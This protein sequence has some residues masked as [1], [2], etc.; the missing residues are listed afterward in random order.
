MAEVDEI[1]ALE[2]V[3]DGFCVG[4]VSSLTGDCDLVITATGVPSVVDEE[5]LSNVRD[6]TLLANAGHFDREF[7]LPALDEMT[8]GTEELATHRAEHTP[9]RPPSRRHRARPHGEPRRTATQRQLHRVDG[10][11]VRVASTL[12]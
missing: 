1:K 6:G 9:R 12:P 8:V 4:T 7:D 10:P 2:A 11:G 3:L 5:A